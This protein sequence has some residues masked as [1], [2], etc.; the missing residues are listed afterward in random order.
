VLPEVLVIK[1]LLLAVLTMEAGSWLLKTTRPAAGGTPTWL[2]APL[3]LAA[4]VVL[5]TSQTMPPDSA[6]NTNR[7]SVEK[8]LT[9]TAGAQQNTYEEVTGGNG[10]GQGCGGGPSYHYRHR[11][12]TVG[13]QAAYR[14][15]TNQNGGPSTVGLGLWSGND[16]TNLSVEDAYGVLADTTVNFRLF[17]VHP[18]LAGERR[19]L[20][21][22]EFGYRAGVYIG[23]LNA[24]TTN[25]YTISK[26]QLA[27]VPDLLFW[28][29]KRRLFYGQA[30]L[31][32]G[33]A[34]LG[35]YSLRLGAGSGLGSDTGSGLGAGLMLPFAN[36]GQVSLQF[37][38]NA[39]INVP[40]TGL[41]LEPYAAS[42]FDHSH[43]ISLRL[44]YRLSAKKKQ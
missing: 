28:W 37:Y 27:V 26:P 16:R 10:S 12:V 18:F 32:Y 29:G 35:P 17:A 11:A 23:K 7:P 9:L 39:T 33:A 2:S 42:N 40:N 21:G 44:H 3:G 6:R 41:S 14:F 31:G 38:V 15:S 36:Y 8:G 20:R 4:M 34:L 1:A 25:E 19:R 30:E 22:F 5:L 43:Q 24:P 13:A